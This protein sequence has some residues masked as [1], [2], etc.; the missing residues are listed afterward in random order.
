MQSKIKLIIAD[1]HPIVRQ[2][3]V[4]IIEQDAAYAIVAQCGEGQETLRLIGEL[5]PDIV[6]VDISMPGLDGLQIV[7]SSLEKNVTSRFIILTMYDDVE[8][9]DQAME[10]GVKGYLLKE[11]AVNELMECLHAVNAGIPY[12]CPE[13]SS[14]LVNR[15]IQKERHSPLDKLTRTEQQIL[16]FI[17]ENK[18]SREIADELFVSLRTIQNHRNNITHKLGLKGHNKLLQFALENKNHL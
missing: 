7:T 15:K 16:K 2:G 4:N 1:D 5:K 6:I 3:L 12:I 13:V 9:F 10:L 11:N 8:Y 17:A 14:H 18:T